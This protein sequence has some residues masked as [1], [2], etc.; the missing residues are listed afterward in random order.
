MKHEK[1]PTPIALLEAIELGAEFHTAEVGEA[2]VWQFVP[3][4]SG[5]VVCSLWGSY[6]DIY[7]GLQA[8]SDIGEPETVALAVVTSGWAAPLPQD[9]PDGENI[10]TPP[11]AHPARRRV[12]L[13]ALRSLDGGSAS[14]IHFADNGE[15]IDD[16]GNA[17]GAL[18]D[19]LGDALDSARRNYS[20]LEQV[21]DEILNN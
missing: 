2:Q 15:N 17:H 9:D 5:R 14:R 16:H 8:F 11:S 20:N 3:N 18:A 7:D 12:S 21:L 10:T 13:I 6:G 4:A 1:I 19:A